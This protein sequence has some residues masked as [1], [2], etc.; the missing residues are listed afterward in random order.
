MLSRIIVGGGLVL[1]SAL[2]HEAHAA[3]KRGLHISDEAVSQ[4]ARAP[5]EALRRG[6]PPL[7]YLRSQSIP[8]KRRPKGVRLE[9][10]I[11]EGNYGSKVYRV[12]DRLY[13]ELGKLHYVPDGRRWSRLGTVVATMGATGP[14]VRFAP[15]QVPVPWPRV[16]DEMVAVLGERARSTIPDPSTVLAG[17]ERAKAAAASVTEA[18][19]GR[20]VTNDAIVS[21]LFRIRPTEWKG[22]FP[23]R[24]AKKLTLRN[25]DGSPFVTLSFRRRFPS[26]QLAEEVASAVRAIEDQP[27]KQEWIEFFVASPAGW[28]TYQGVRA[29]ASL[30]DQAI[31]DR[32]AERLAS[33]S[34]DFVRMGIFAEISSVSPA[35]RWKLIKSVASTDRSADVRSYAVKA[36]P[37]LSADPADGAMLVSYLKDAVSEKTMAA[38]IERYTPALK[39]EPWL[40]TLSEHDR[41]VSDVV[42]AWRS[43]AN[44]ALR[45]RLAEQLR[46]KQPALAEAV[47]AKSAELDRSG[48]GIQISAQ[49]EWTEE[50]VAAFEAKLAAQ[51]PSHP[52]LYTDTH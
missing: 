35:L 39:N 41:A 14:E 34:D 13:V 29:Y 36:T 50:R 16:P 46:V 30:A 10:P 43:I 9:H 23:A 7:S 17:V 32:L 5:L 48:K 18:T 12:G 49:D 31:R 47:F 3:S 28:P 42:P 26:E 2:C 1:S 20:S 11:L 45:Q 27:L 15:P 38:W 22:F 25:P 40:S 6:E 8:L 21:E 37:S 24:P 51:P 4:V 33:H 52:A 19:R 44:A